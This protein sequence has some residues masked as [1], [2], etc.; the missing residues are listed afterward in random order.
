MTCLP[1]HHLWLSPLTDAQLTGGFPCPNLSAPTPFA[2]TPAATPL[3]S[4]GPSKT[5]FG[6]ALGTAM[7]SL[8]AIPSLSLKLPKMVDNGES[9]GKAD[10]KREA[11]YSLKPRFEWA[12][13]SWGAENVEWRFDGEQHTS[14][15]L[16]VRLTSGR[17]TPACILASVEHF[18]KALDKSFPH[19]CAKTE[20]SLPALITLAPLP[21]SVITPLR[22]LIDKLELQP[23][24][25]TYLVDSVFFSTANETRHAR[26]FEGTI[27]ESDDAPRQTNRLKAEML[28]LQIQGSTIVPL[29]EILGGL[30]VSPKRSDSMSDSAGSMSSPDDGETVDED[31]EAVTPDMMASQILPS[32]TGDK[33]EVN[34]LSPTP[35][36]II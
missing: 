12:M 35:S 17:Y 30:P 5:A 34:E 25:V 13:G 7:H 9:R 33:T 11:E 19:A 16:N 21:T 24:V 4:P 15:P 29:K 10:R 22:E 36:L 28:L 32:T 14:C 18:L 3:P 27:P 20:A 23:E 6:S 8:S 31:G 2:G 1:A 26:L